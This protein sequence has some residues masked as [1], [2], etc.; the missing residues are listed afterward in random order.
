[1]LRT[2]QFHLIS[3]TFAVSAGAGLMAIGLMKLYPIEA[4][5]SA[6]VDSVEASAIAGTAMAVFFSVANGIGRIAWGALSDTLGRKRSVVIMAG[7]Q[8]IFL[9]A[10]IPMAGN[11]YL[12]YL[13]AAL[14]GFNYGGNFALFPSLTADEFGDESVGR[15]YPLVFLAYGAGGI[16]FPVLGG[17]LG[18]MGNFPLAFG[19]VAAACISGAVATAFVYPPRQEDV[20]GPLTFHGF[21]ET[22]R[23]AEHGS[24]K[25]GA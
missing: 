20:A 10:F 25:F 15:N 16:A 14:I 9:A 5:T 11:E 8:G 21:V 23:L 18:D 6:G 12:L 2:P 17:V 1:M 3:F 24:T 19:I 7:T 4:L 22:A 13:A